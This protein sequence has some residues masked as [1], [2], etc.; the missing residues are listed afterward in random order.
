MSQFCSLDIFNNIL[1]RKV[2]IVLEELGLSY[3]PIYLKIDKGEHKA[4]PHTTLNPNGRIP[5]LIDHKN[6]DFF[7]W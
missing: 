4:P 3:E 2:A 1:G 7:I 6:N 5:T